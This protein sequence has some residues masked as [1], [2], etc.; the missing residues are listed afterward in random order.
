[1]KEYAKPT[2]I[3]LITVES[4]KSHWSREIGN[5]SAKKPNKAFENPKF[6]SEFS[7][8][9]GLILWGIVEE[10]TSPSTSLSLKY[11]REI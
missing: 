1:M 4:L 8:M 11:P 6:P 7:N 10:P 9:M 3:F 2:P 5:F